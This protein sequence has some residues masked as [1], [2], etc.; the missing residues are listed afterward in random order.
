M[1]TAVLSSIVVILAVSFPL[2]GENKYVGVQ[3]CASCHSTAQGAGGSGDPLHIWQ[4]SKHAGAYR[5]LANMNTSKG[6]QQCEG[7]YLVRMGRGDQYG[8]PTPAA[9]FPHC[10]IC[11]GTAV[12][13][14]P[15]LLAASMDRRDGVQCEACHG[16]GSAHVQVE[17]LKRSGKAIPP[18]EVA[19]ALEAAKAVTF[20]RYANEKEIEAQCKTCHDGMCGDFS[21][22]RMWPM[23]RHS[24]PKDAPPAAAAQ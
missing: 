22:E 24:A 13:A 2:R 19:A 4:G 8:L 6:A 20:K 14:N 17:T 7:L 18:Q 9:E 15:D 11:H 21:F 3:V 1:R 5:T 23:V 10:T 12:G 16:P